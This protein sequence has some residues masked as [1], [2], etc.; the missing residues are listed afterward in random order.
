MIWSVLGSHTGESVAVLVIGTII[1]LKFRRYRAVAA[2]AVGVFSSAATVVAGVFGV[3]VAI[4]AFGWWDP[5]IAE[6]VGDILGAAKALWS[7]AG[8]WVVE[9]ILEWVEGVA[10]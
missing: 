6:I 3:L 9:T 4:V 1:L 7:L 8:E 5:P 10:D 2:A